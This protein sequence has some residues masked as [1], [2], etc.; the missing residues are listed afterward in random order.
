MKISLE[1]L[2]QYFPGEL[3]AQVAADAL[4]QGG[5]PVELI[6]TV[7]EDT[8]IDVEV[9]SNRGDCLSHLGVARELGA[10]LN[11]EFKDVSPDVAASAVAASSAAGVAIE[12]VDLCPHYTARII[13][14]VKV[15]PS[16]G[17]MVRRLEA[18]GLRAIN[19]VVDVT[20][21]VMHELGQPLHAFDFD[22][23][24]GRRVVV[25]NAVPGE[26]LV[27]IDGHE[28]V[29]AGDMLVIADAHNPVALAGVM[30]GR[31]SEVSDATVNILL[32]SARFEALSVRKTARRLAMMSDSSYR[33]ERGIDPA[34]PLKASLRAA[35][36]ILETAGGELLAG[37]VEAG[38]AH[39][40]PKKLS[41]RLAKL[42]AILGIELPVET[43]L[44]ALERLRFSP[45]RKGDVVEVI[46]PTDRL[47]VN[48]EID[49]VEEV[50]RVAGYDR[51]P[52]RD[53]IAIRLTPPDPNAKT[54]NLVR[55]SLVAGGLFESLTFTFVS[56]ALADDFRPVESPS[57][58]RV[59]SQVRKADARLRPSLIPG[60][61]ESIRRNENVGTHGV[62]LFETGSTFW[63]GAAGDKVVERQRLGLAGGDLPALRGVVET[64][65]TRLD[66]SR[67]IRVVPDQ[68][69][70]FAVAAAGR[71]EWGGETI[72]F[73]GKIDRKIA[74]KISLRDIPAA[75]EIEVDAL[76][77][78]AQ[79]VPQLR[80]LPKFPSVRR[81]LSLVVTERTR[82]ERIESIVMELELQNLEGIEYVTTYR[83]KPLEK[84]HKSV[85]IALV[86]RSATTTLTSEQVEDAVQRVVQSAKTQLN[87]TLRA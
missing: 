27:S 86:F 14:N 37:V 54:M 25:R 75:A 83:G 41:L 29:L 72:G 51:I 34:L 80:A 78:G 9:T 59:E 58:P 68:R 76:L 43:V 65:L 87:A 69:P 3:D 82:Y 21:Y 44:D 77:R 79:P 66:A 85:T 49:L 35:Q 6:E 55:E 31:D 52:V 13:R 57:L 26:K 42:K 81:D 39:A 40:S 45:V 67:P 24:D 16:P 2:S 53:E 19:N 32:E 23:L 20:N 22:K 15:R 70:G 38:A 11:R 84:G 28:R 64:M 60:L 10:L 36:L 18:V 73:I 1:W 5:L 7:G 47:D 63:S 12:A 30:G 71:I 46:I 17:W 61:L 48:V 8:V 50:A 33:F 62:R 74:E 4:T 56:D